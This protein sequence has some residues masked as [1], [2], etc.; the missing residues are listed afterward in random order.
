MRKY[1]NLLL[2]L[3]TFAGAFGSE[4]EFVD[5]VKS[6]PQIYQPIYGHKEI[7]NF[8]RSCVDREK[9]IIDAVRR[10]ID[11]SKKANISVLDI[12][13]SQ[14]YFCFKLKEVFGSQVRVQGIDILK[15]NIE[16]CNKLKD[17]NSMDIDFSYDALTPNFIDSIDDVDVVLLLSVIHHETRKSGSIYSSNGGCFDYAQHLLKSLADKS[18]L[19][20]VELA[21]KGEFHDDFGDLPTN[22]LDW[23][24]G[25]DSYKKLG[26]FDRG[27]VSETD[28]RSSTSKINMRP[29]FAISKLSGMF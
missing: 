1:L 26:D 19:V 11:V 6:M 23:F 16:L 9:V 5:V 2:F 7:S 14:G 13:C 8:E 18:G 24:K 22:C 28:R 29:L 17:E 12:G 25:I 10:Y 3:S 21:L 4:R 15:E 27:L 20:L